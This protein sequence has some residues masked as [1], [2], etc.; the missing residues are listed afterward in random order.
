MLAL[1]GRT[2]AVAACGAVS[3][4]PSIFVEQVVMRWD[5]FRLNVMRAR[6]ASHEQNTA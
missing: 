4:Q 2:V 5:R 6:F 1:S 3:V